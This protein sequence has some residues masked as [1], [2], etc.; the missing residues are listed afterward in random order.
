MKGYRVGSLVHAVPVYVVDSL[1]AGHIKSVNGIGQV[2]GRRSRVQG[3]LYRVWL[4]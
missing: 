1:L 2:Q 3:R 4:Q